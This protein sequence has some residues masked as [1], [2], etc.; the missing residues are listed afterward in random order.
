MSHPA[1]KVTDAIDGKWMRSNLIDENLV[2]W[3]GASLTKNGFLRP[4]LDKQWKPKESQFATIVS[5]GRLLYVFSAA[6]RLT[7]E[8][9]YRI[10][11]ERGGDFLLKYFGDNF[12][13]GF[14]WRVT[15]DGAVSDRNKNLYG[16]AFAIF[17]L[18]H[19]YLATRNDRYRQEAMACW[20]TCKRNLRDNSGGYFA[21]A[22]ED[23]SKPNGHTQNPIMHMFEALLALYDATGST[24]ILE[25]VECIAEFVCNRLLVAESGFIPEAFDSTWTIPAESNGV[26]WI[27]MGHQPEWAFLLSEGV[28]R[29][30]PRSYL[31]K[32]NRLLN[33]AI[34][35]GYDPVN[36]GLGESE[37]PKK[38]G[39]WQQAEF[40]RALIR[41][42]DLHGRDDLLPILAKSL[43]LI[44]TDF[45]DPVDGGWPEYGTG[46]KGN[47]WKVG[48]H[49]V[50]MYLEGIRATK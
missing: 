14:Y 6:H 20:Q 47:I 43:K 33:Y 22:Q 38:K 40:V 13:G 34:E 9:R 12:N 25:D 27:E 2:R 21:D 37:D 8:D 30:L 50:G 24:E 19:A 4:N 36:G 49:E 45:I 41:Y 23:F 15:P 3:L 18:S 42:S 7:G 48:S 32:G 44:Q 35:R 16:Q 17:G 10:A 31:T 26:V 29:G 1:S 39:A 46:D 11:A 28:E 5:Q